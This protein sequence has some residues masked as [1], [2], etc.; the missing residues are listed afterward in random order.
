MKYYVGDILRERHV[1]ESGEEWFTN[2]F[3]IRNNIFDSDHEVCYDTFMLDPVVDEVFTQDGVS[4]KR[5]NK[6]EYVGRIDMSMMIG[7]QKE[8]E[9]IRERCEELEAVRDRIQKVIDLNEKMYG[10]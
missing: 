5:L 2:I 8:Y 4:E 1:E 3:V 10:K 9:I 7:S 6:C